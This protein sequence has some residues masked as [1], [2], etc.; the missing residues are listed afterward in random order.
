LWK[1][2]SLSSNKTSFSSVERY[3][4]SVERLRSSL[5]MPCTFSGKVPLLLLE[6][7]AFYVVDYEVF[8]AGQ[9]LVPDIYKKSDNSDKLTSM[10]NKTKQNLTC[11]QK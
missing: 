5:E 11:S 8:F 9:R 7:P 6:N 4:S 1:G 10:Q 3:R 2:S